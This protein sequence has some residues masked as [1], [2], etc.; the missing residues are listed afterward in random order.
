MIK[1]NCQVCTRRYPGCQNVET[2]DD[3]ADYRKKLDDINTKRRLESLQT[4]AD[5]D[6]IVSKHKGTRQKYRT[7]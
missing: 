3:Y 2:C 5:R 1:C 7:S 6:R 4:I